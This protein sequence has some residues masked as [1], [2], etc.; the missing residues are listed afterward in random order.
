MIDFYNKKRI[1]DFIFSYTK[2][3]V[4]DE[5]LYKL[6]KKAIKSSVPIIKKEISD[7]LSTIIKI[8][9][10]ENILEL[11]TGIAYSTLVM[12][13]AN[14]NSKIKTVENFPSRIAEAKKNIK[15][16]DKKNNIILVEE[17]INDYLKNEN[18]KFDFI[19]LD[20]AKAQYPIWFKY[21]KNLVNKNG[22]IF[23]D[24]I[25]RDG[26]IFESHF[27]IKKRNRTIYKRMREFLSILKNNIEFDTKI[28]NIG[29]GITISFKNK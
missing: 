16:F 17:D 26:E 4:E 3:N 11:G 1:D 7:I 13:Y 18:E 9:K 8:Y 6:R 20:A 23:A 5:I 24:N 22:I 15:K 12:L 29:D 10:P 27:A 2:E 19:F 28:I 25:F 21:I 14:P